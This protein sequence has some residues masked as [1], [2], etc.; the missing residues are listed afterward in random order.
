VKKEFVKVYFMFYR[1]CQDLMRVPLRIKYVEMN[2]VC[3]N[4]SGPYDSMKKKSWCDTIYQY[5]V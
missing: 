4:C 2:R 1:A 3:I 5:L